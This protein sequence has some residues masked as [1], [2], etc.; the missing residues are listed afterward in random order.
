VLLYQNTMKLDDAAKQSENCFLT[1]DWDG[2]ESRLPSLLGLSP[3]YITSLS[4]CYCY[5]YFYYYHYSVQSTHMSQRAHQRRL[6]LYRG[7]ERH[8]MVQECSAP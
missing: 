4:Y 7:L 1:P 6:S 8:I 3:R 5:F 2:F